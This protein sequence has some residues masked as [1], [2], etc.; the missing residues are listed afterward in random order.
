MKETPEMRSREVSFLHFLLTPH[1]S[2]LTPA[3]EVFP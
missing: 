1:F 3:F 2:L